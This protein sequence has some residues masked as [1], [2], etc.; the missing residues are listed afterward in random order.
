[1]DHVVDLTMGLTMGPTTN[2]T[3]DL[4]TDLTTDLIME[5]GDAAPVVLA[6]AVEAVAL[7]WRMSCRMFLVAPLQL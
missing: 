6:D 5:V 3:M 7:A 4:T 1:M 2:L